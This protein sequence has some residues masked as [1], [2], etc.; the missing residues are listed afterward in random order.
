MRSGDGLV[1]RV[2]PRFGRLTRAQA[3]GLCALAKTH[4][5]GMID[6]TNRANLQIRGVMDAGHAPLLRA[7]QTLDLVEADPAAEARRNILVTPFWQPGD[8]SQ[9]LTGALLDTLPHLPD[10]PAK[11]GFAV[12]C[13]PAL[14]LSSAP[15]DFRLERSADGLILRADGAAKGWPVTEAEAMDALREMVHWFDARRDGA[16][17]RMAALVAQGDL[18]TAWQCALPLPAAPPPRP[19][20]RPQGALLGVPFGQIDAGDLARL[21]EASDATAL[22]VTPWRMLLLEGAALPRA[23]Q[24]FITAPGD[25]LMAVDACPGAP[26][27]PQASVET[28]AL[29]RA[30]APHLPG[31]HVSGCAK[32][33]ARP[34]PARATLVGRNGRFDLVEQAAPWEDPSRT[35]LT[36]EALMSGAIED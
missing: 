36:P 23:P 1:V 6:L 13:G 17:R 22:R 34:R 33:C 27:C 32:G 28:R 5:S 12:D 18:P 14:L 20:K 30:L 11:V 25:P 24:G 2:R 3:L 26:F 15:A 16:H 31:L 7:L 19:G 21:L 4:G 8:L 29:A 35:G 10:L 9:R